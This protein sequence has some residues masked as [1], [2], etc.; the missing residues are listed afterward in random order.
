MNR[1]GG[2]ALTE[3]EN[4]M[5]DPFLKIHLNILPIR[6]VYS[7]EH[8]TGKKMAP[9]TPQVGKYNIFQFNIH[10]LA[11][12]KLYIF[13]EIWYSLLFIFILFKES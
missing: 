8:Y 10:I 12:L 3:W 2:H 11:F 1:W 9:I 4:K 6:S 7:N 13:I 5:Q